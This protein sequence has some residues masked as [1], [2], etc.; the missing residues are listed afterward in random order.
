VTR[1]WKS[2]NNVNIR[3]MHTHTVYYSEQQHVWGR[4]NKAQRDLKEERPLEIRSCT[5]EDNIKM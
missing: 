5:W 4:I 3:N 2:L 1:V